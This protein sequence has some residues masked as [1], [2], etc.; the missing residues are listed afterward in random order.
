MAMLQCRL[1][2]LARRPRILRT[3]PAA[4]PPDKPTSGP[5]SGPR[6]CGGHWCQGTGAATG[7]SVEWMTHSLEP[8]AHSLERMAHSLE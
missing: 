1:R 4:A 6:N 3:I 8:M 5:T 7:H 2:A